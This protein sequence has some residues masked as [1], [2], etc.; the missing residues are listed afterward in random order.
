[1]DLHVFMLAHHAFNRSRSPWRICFER[2][3]ELVPHQRQHYGPTARRP[4]PTSRALAGL[5]KSTRSA[6]CTVVDLNRVYKLLSILGRALNSLLAYVLN[7]G[8]VVLCSKKTTQTKVVTSKRLDTTRII[9]S[10]D[11]RS[12]PLWLSA[13]HIKDSRIVNTEGNATAATLRA[14]MR[15]VDQWFLS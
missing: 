10:T 5:A 6:A 1:V 2:R 7:S 9:L 11:V 13:M 4:S 14:E 12:T 3:R 8:C 15:Y